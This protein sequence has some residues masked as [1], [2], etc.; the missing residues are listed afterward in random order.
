MKKIIYF[1]LTLLICLSFENVYASS[2]EKY[3]VG[4][5]I[6][7]DP[8]A[9]SL[10]ETGDT[11]YTWYAIKESGYTDK[12]LSIIL[13]H[14]LGEETPL[15]SKYTSVPVEQL[16][17]DAAN[18]YLKT[19]TSNWKYQGRLIKKQ[20]IMNIIKEE[21]NNDGHYSLKNY[22]WLGK[23]L[24]G[25]YDEYW[26]D[27][28]S[29]VAQAWVVG[30]YETDGLS[31]FTNK[32]FIY[33]GIVQNA[34]VRPVIDIE[35]KT[36]TNKAINTTDENISISSIP[37][38]I[39]KISK[40][41]VKEYLKDSDVYK[42]L[43]NIFKDKKSII[44]YNFNLYDADNNPIKPE[45]KVTVNIKLPT[46]I[47]QNKLKLWYI[48]E[49]FNQ[50]ELEYSIQNNTLSFETDHFSTYVLTEDMD[51]EIV[52]VSDTA[53]NITMIGVTIGLAILVMGIMV[54]VQTLLKSKNN[55]QNICK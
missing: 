51:E 47:D 26:I 29:N 13:D 9:D 33:H 36:V 35:K 7:Y 5:A 18:N 14:N 34:Y 10:C 15:V 3:E 48:T 17:A 16:V 24:D 1:V 38:T 42:R 11:C 30:N 52:N 27:A 22:P 37:S 31:I 54:I 32:D 12:N 20:E 4:D 2:Y 39:D 25:N 41:E 45:S 46:D 43:Q 21:P 19:L 53:F 44:A 23:N 6:K 49:E 8:V 28:F 50:Q 40:A 55:K